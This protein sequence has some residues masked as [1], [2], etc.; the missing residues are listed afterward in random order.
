[1]G[2]DAPPRSGFALSPAGDTSGDGFADLLIGVY[3][4]AAGGTSKGAVYLV[5]G[6]VGSGAPVSEGG[7]HFVGEHSV[8]WLG[9]AMAGVG[10]VNGDGL[11]DFYL[12]APGNDG[13]GESAGAV[14][15]FHG[16][17]SGEVWVDKA[18]AALFGS[19]AGGLAGGALAAAGDLDGD[20]LV[21]LVVG[22]T[23]GSSRVYVVLSPVQGEMS[24]DDADGLLTSPSA[25][26]EAGAALIAAGDLDGDGNGDLAIG[27]PGEDT[28]DGGPNAGVVYGVLQWSGEQ[29]L[30]SAVIRWEGRAPENRAGSALAAADLDRDGWTDLAI[31]APG[32]D[33][34][35]VL[36]G[37][38]TGTG[39][40]GDAP[41]RLIGGG[42]A[43]AFFAG[44]LVVGN[45]GTGDDPGGVWIW[46]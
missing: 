19:V 27:A 36:Y 14:Y 12:G 29:S 13:G 7:A 21:D 15:L 45:P 16:P 3:P 30:S 40:L 31:G 10:D 28:R 33:E 5:D 18:D 32:A 9:V 17:Q 1:L 46:R 24:L 35:Y 11:D 22:A 20:G 6:P 23:G 38:L 37:P 42:H 44:G 2:E 26:A 4:E 8:D 41:L 43:V 34:T 39:V 25:S